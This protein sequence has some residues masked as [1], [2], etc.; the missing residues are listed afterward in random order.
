MFAETTAAITAAKEAFALIKTLKEARDQTVIENATGQLSEKVTEL[1]MLN[2]ELASRY[3]SEK[4]LTIKL[5]DEI[6]KFTAFSSQA[7]NYAIHTTESG[8][9]VYRLK[10][11]PDAQV[12]THYVCANCFQK[13]EISILQPTGKVVSDSLGSFCAQYLC[14]RCNA[15]YL[16]NKIPRN[17]AVMPKPIRRGRIM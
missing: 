13:R 8:S 9:T 1:Q 14:P 17:P 5:T 6:A 11:S 16:M 3:H 10:E 7:E 4:Q 12:K 2:A 15:T